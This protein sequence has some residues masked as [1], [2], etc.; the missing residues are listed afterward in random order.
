MSAP[1][2]DGGERQDGQSP[3]SSETIRERTALETKLLRAAE[4]AADGV[5]TAED[6]RE[7]REWAQTALALSQSIVILDPDLVSPQGVPVDAL[8]PPAPRS[9]DARIKADKSRSAQSG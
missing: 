8:H 5:A 2:A 3:P 1:V 4:I 6:P 9:Q 7:A